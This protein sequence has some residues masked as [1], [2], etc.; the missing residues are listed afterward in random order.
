MDQD[1]DPQIGYK[2]PS[3]AIRLGPPAPERQSVALPSKA[4]GAKMPYYRLYFMDP[5]S[6]HIDR[7]AEFQA[8]DD[9]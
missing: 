1:S 7:F 4:G 9:R 5:R 8:P 2:I 6:G 3:L